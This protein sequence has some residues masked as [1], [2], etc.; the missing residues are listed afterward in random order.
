MRQACVIIHGVGEQRPMSTIRKF[1]NAV[2]QS[3]SSERAHFWSKP[4]RMSEN[5]ELRRLSVTSSS[6]RPITDFYEYYWVYHMQGT[7]YRHVL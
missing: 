4:D 6:Q 5:F 1:V 3:K 7:K 2:L